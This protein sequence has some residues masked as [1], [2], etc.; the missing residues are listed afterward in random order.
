MK[1]FLIEIEKSNAHG[2]DF[3]EYK[4]H[5]IDGNIFFIFRDNDNLKSIGQAQ[6]MH[7]PTYQPIAQEIKE[8]LI[9]MIKQ[10]GDDLADMQFNYD[11]IN[12][13]LFNLQICNKRLETLKLI[14]I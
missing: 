10:Y 4:L 13:G 3:L 11:I 9:E 7:L 2:L 14:G 8:W 5:Y 6:L 1:K 12:P